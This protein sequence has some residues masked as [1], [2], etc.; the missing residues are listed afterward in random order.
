MNFLQNVGS[1][2]RGMILKTIKY[3][4]SIP[5]E[6]QKKCYNPLYRPQ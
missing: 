2:Q 6:K 3:E 5:F 4:R 1:G